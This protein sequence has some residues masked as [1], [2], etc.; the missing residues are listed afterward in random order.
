MKSLSSPKSPPAATVIPIGTV[1]SMIRQSTLPS[2]L[3]E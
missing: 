2:G 3:F 1:R